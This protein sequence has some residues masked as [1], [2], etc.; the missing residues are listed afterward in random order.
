M[1][2]ELNTRKKKRRIRA[3]RGVTKCEG[4]NEYKEK[5]E[6]LNEN[7]GAEVIKFIVTAA[8]GKV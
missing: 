1:I 7:G 4:R 3:Q 8:Q 6:T 2:G 5:I